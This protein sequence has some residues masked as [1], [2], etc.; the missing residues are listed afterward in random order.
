MLNWTT[1]K[2]LFENG[3]GFTHLLVQQ[4]NE[5]TRDLMATIECDRMHC[6]RVRIGHHLARLVNLLLYPNASGCIQISQ[7]DWRCSLVFRHRPLAGASSC[8]RAKT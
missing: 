4:L 3:A 5:R 6:A 2:W 7:K 1:C 8:W